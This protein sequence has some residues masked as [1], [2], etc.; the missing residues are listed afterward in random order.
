MGELANRRRTTELRGRLALVLLLATFGASCSS[1]RPAVRPEPEAKPEHAAKPAQE[2]APRPQTTRR[3]AKKPRRRA[4]LGEASYYHP[5]LEG[6]LTASGV[7]YRAEE[8]TCAH[9]T[10]PFGTRVRVTR[11]D[12]AK[13]V[14]VVV[15]DRGP[16]VEGRIVDL[17]M[18][19]AR[20]LGMIE[21]GHVPVRLEIVHRPPK[22]VAARRR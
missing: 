20:E 16:F 11:L 15:N 18:A 13:S 6:N 7:P 3:P 22:R 14:S 17:S 9:R 21:K 8:M 4:E 10:L 1:Q 5:S 2:P 19:A 12:E